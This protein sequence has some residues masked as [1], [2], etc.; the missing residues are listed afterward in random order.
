MI[1]VKDQL[2]N[3]LFSR[4]DY[5][6]KKREKGKNLDVL[7]TKG[8]WGGNFTIGEVAIWQS[9]RERWLIMMGKTKKK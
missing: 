2:E 5:E 4:E 9:V 3:L 1:M 7:S 6:E 8:F